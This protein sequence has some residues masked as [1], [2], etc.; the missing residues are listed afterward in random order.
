MST[1]KRIVVYRDIQRRNIIRLKKNI[2]ATLVIKPKDGLITAL[3]KR[4]KQYIINYKGDNSKDLQDFDKIFKTLI[5]DIRS[6]LNLKKPKQPFTTYFIAFRDFILDKATFIS[7]K[8]ANKAFSH[9]LIVVDITEIATTTLS[10]DPFV[11]S[12][13]TKSRYTLTVFMGIIIDIKALK[14]SIASYG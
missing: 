5:I 8:L 3:K 14:K 10:T 9:L 4:F 2:K 1:K 6:E 11:Y 7:I 12:I 13:N